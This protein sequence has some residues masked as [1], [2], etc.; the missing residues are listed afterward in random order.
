MID[1]ISPVEKS[2]TEMKSLPRIPRRAGFRVC[3]FIGQV[4]PGTFRFL[5][6]YPAGTGERRGGRIFSNIVKLRACCQWAL[7]AAKRVFPRGE[8]IFSYQ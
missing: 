2:S 4:L 5:S 7:H 3:R 1:C 6:R 8:N